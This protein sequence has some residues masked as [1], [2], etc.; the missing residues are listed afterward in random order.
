[1]FT[2]DYGTTGEIEV[3]NQE[4]LEIL[5]AEADKNDVAYVVWEAGYGNILS[6][7]IKNMFTGEWE[8]ETYNQ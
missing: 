3:A 5:L 6:S 2:V 8:R 7:K 4:E 1:M